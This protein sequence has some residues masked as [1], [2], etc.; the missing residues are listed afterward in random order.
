MPLYQKHAL[1]KEGEEYTINALRAQNYEIVQKNYRSPY[2]E[3]DI[4]ARDGH[5]LV[6]IEVKTRTNET[7]EQ[8]QKS[9]TYHK[10][11]KITKTA[12]C[13]IHSYQDSEIKEYRF[14]VVIIKKEKDRYDTHHLKDAFPPAEVGEF[15]A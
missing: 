5:F 6:F 12:M 8:A 4:I 10:Q 11:K 1:G 14:D 9:I 13:F 3:I 7:I 15:F 2:G